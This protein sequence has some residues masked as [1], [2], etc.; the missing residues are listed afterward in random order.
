MKKLSTLFLICLFITAGSFSTFATVYLV[1][2]GSGGNSWRAAGD[3][4]VNINLNTLGRSL[5]YWLRDM[6]TAS[7]FVAGDQIWI[8]AGIYEV[9]NI[10][11]NNPSPNLA[12]IYGGFAGTETAVS[13]RVKGLNA[14][15]FTNETIIRGN[16]KN[17][18][19]IRVEGLNITYDGLTMDYFTNAVTQGS[20]MN[21]QNCKITNCSNGAVSFSLTTSNT[22]N[23][24]AYTK[25]SYFYNNTVSGTS[26]NP[27]AVSIVSSIATTYELSGCLFEN[28]TSTS[29]GAG[30]SACIKVA[31]TVYYN[32]NISNCVFKNNK[33]TGASGNQ[34]SSIISVINNTA[35]LNMTNC[36]G[37][38]NASDPSNVDA[39]YLQKGNI[40]NCTFVNNYK[41]ASLNPSTGDIVLKNTV[42]WGTLANSGDITTAGTTDNITLHN[43][44]YRTV[45]TVFAD[46]S[47]IVLPATNDEGIN[48]PHFTDPVNNIW[49]IMNGS[50]LKDAG[51]STGAPDTDLVGTS[52][53]QGSG[54]DIGTYE[55]TVNVGL[56]SFNSDIN[57]LS[58]YRGGFIANFIGKVQV[59]T[60]AGQEIKNKN[61]SIGDKIDLSSG[62]YIVRSTSTK[63]VYTQK[64]VL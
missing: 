32:A 28:N 39:L 49:T 21:I 26:A 3:G 8:A 24:S 25:D 27:A 50:S 10:N 40:T 5:T 64:I 60:V 9:L 11:Y 45:G 57:T 47:P 1:E 16:N 13:Q 20:N 29:T 36:L 41:G 35:T 23:L 33:N 63:G 18:L 43:C 17:S 6:S 4:E 12:A 56:N 38:G 31:G 59:Y 42:F 22:P 19:F 2:N 52:R 62:I 7:T 54:Y 30:N 34:R 55:L 58:V 15:D 48:A 46:N 51:T 37:Y 44:A 61:V 53:P 14:W